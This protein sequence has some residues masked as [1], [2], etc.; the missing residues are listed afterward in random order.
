MMPDLRDDS[1]VW[2]VK[3]EFYL[4]PGATIQSDRDMNG[5]DFVILVCFLW[6]QL[7]VMARIDAKDPILASHADRQNLRI[8]IDM[9]L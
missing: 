6:P 8:S 3:A 9:S 4:A 2:S 7:G 5:I 1:R